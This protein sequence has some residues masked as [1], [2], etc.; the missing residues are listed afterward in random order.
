MLTLRNITLAYGPT[1]L[2]D[3]AEI[4]VRRGERVALV[5]RNG[6]G[7]STLLRILAGEVEPDHMSVEKSGDVR[8][9]RLTQD[10]PAGTTGSVYDVIAA[11]LGRIG[12][13]LARFHDLTARLS[14]GE[15]VMDAFSAAQAEVDAADGWT[16]AQRVEAT[17]S[18]L[19]LGADT[20]FEHLSGGQQRR[21][22]L[23]RALV[24]EPDLLLLDEPTNHLDIAAIDQLEDI[25]A[26]WSGALLFITHDRAFLRRLAT[27]IV[28]LDRGYLTS[29]S[30]NYDQFLAD[31]DK[32]LA[33]EAQAQAAFDKKLAAEEVWIRQ[34]VKAR[35]TRN[36]SRVR[37]L[38]AMRTERA[39]RR[40]RT[41]TANI[42]TQDV[43]RS[44]R[45]VVVAEHVSYSRGEQPIVDDLSTTI[46]RG[47]KVGIIGPNGCGKT[48]LIQ[49][50]LDRL[51][52]DTG[53]LKLGTNLDIAYFDQQ[54]AA[55]DDSATV[56]DNVGQGRTSI[57]VNG[58]DRHVMSYLGDFLFS[59]KRARSPAS[60]LSGGERNRLLLAKLFTR[61]ANLL[62]MDEPTN[63]L[64]IETLELLEER[65]MA[66]QG[67]LIIVSH[68]RAFLDNVVTSS[69]VFEGNA[70]VGDYIGGY[71]DWLQ[72]RPATHDNQSAPKT[73]NASSGT[74][75]KAEARST[76]GL[77]RAEQKELREL[78]GRIEE[79]ENRVA[80][81]ES[82]FGSPTIYTG[83]SAAI[84]NK[85][86]ELN[87][88]RAQVETAMARWEEL[89]SR[90]NQ[91]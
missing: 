33:D 76:A 16:F 55:I 71:S 45:N 11:G 86:T 57:T 65:L 47:D 20:R 67:T 68:D 46:Q 3:D 14:A 8:I 54:R 17:I 24:Q 77:S 82:E 75:A 48:T 30:G 4:T 61:P 91:S 63:D 34:G 84:A 21:V 85:T 41:G 10:V 52:P 43:E 64:D 37:E 90:Q 73:R 74:H 53:T 70:Q 28:D 62:V 44:G 1:P 56:V 19:S 83:D 5:G 39:Q 78:P 81:T 13:A 2:L 9:A 88:L 58:K 22:L 7:K 42:T 89:E 80:A 25:L 66:F 32:A 12:D 26:N 6:T 35:R 31:K 79:L 60:V 27:R 15:D 72:Q 29:W 40:E 18:R 51:A 36:E 23:G 38:K 87:E 49:L 69:L 50:L 59:P